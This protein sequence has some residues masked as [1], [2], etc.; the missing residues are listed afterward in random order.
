MGG[1]GRGI[2]THAV[3]TTTECDNV[4]GKDM[5]GAGW[6]GLPFFCWKKTQGCGKKLLLVGACS[7]GCPLFLTQLPGGGENTPGPLEKCK[8]KKKKAKVV[9]G[10]AIKRI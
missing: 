10:E 8:K 3:E 2:P 7:S 4:M 6:T 1:A 5:Q 9:L